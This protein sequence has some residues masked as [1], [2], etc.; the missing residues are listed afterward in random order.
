MAFVENDT[1]MQERFSL[2]LLEPGEIYFE[3]YSVYYYPPGLSEEEAIKKRQK[4]RLKICSKSIL[5]DPKDSQYPL[6]KFPFKE[7]EC[8]EEWAGSLFSKL[9]ASQRVLKLESRL[10]IEMC[11][12]NIVAPYVFRK[13]LAQH[14]FHLNYVTI[15]DC[16]PQMCQL[17]R[18]STLPLADQTAMINAIVLSRQSRVKFNTSWLED[19]YEKTVLECQADRIT[20]LVT[21][22]G[23]V[24]LTS[25]RL[26]FQAFN[27]VNPIPV[28]KIKLSDVCR[29]VKRRFLL[30]Q[31]GMEVYCR[32]GAPCS[33]LYLSLKT[34]DVRDALYTRLLAQPL[35][36]L[37]ET[38]QD[39][40]TFRWQN[41]T[42]SNLDYLLYLNSLA[43]RSFNDLTQYPVM[44]WV[45]ADYTSPDLDLLSDST[46]RDLSKPMGAL[47]PARL[48]GLKARFAEMPEPKF[49]YGSH[50]STPGYVL[51][52]LARVAPEYMLC[53]QN[54]KFDQADRMFNDISET[55]MNCL[56]GQ[57]DFKELIPEFY[58]GK[59][60]FLTNKRNINFGYRQ[61]GKPVGDVTLPA[62]AK[63]PEEFVTKLQDAL[64]SSYVSN[65]I[66][67]WI[68]LVFGYKQR[69]EE[70][71]KAD[72][73]FYYLT[74][75]GAVD[76]DSIIDLNER[77][78]LEI[79]IMEFGQ[80]P[81]QLFT[82][83]HP[84]R[85]STMP[86]PQ[87]PSFP[88]ASRGHETA[89][90]AE[91]IGEV[92]ISRDQA[93][94]PSPSGV[95]VKMLQSLEPYLRHS[96]HKEAVTDVKI[97][98]D[99]KNIY[100][101]SQDSLLKM[102]SLEDQRQLRSINLSNMALSC[103]TVM[104]DNR[105]IIVGSWDN[106]VYF[107]SVEYGRVLDS[108]IAHDDAVSSL[109][110]EN[111]ML[112]TASW[113]STVKIWQYCTPEGSRS[114]SAEY[115]MVL[116]HE[117]CVM[118]VDVRS[119]D[120]LV[121]TGTDGGMIHVWEMAT[122]SLREQYHAHDGAVNAVLFSIDGRRVFSCGRDSF[123][124]VYDME[125]S[126]EIFA[127]DV[128][129]ELRCMCLTG[130]KL[131][132]GSNEGEVIVWDMFKVALIHR[133]K[134]HTGAIT[135]LYLSESGCLVT[136]GEDKEVVLWKSSVS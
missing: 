96:L 74:Y 55:W 54:G 114:K 48:E 47:N 117:S 29:V 119:T 11:E 77:A 93:P 28:I 100:S 95:N 49:L 41:G 26:Y 46:F 8:M 105:T 33:H 6:L 1:S 20:P 107:Y 56:K 82:T 131:I 111:D 108:V 27:N 34:P 51:F 67:Q 59:G 112:I 38:G 78:S 127:K 9:D 3:D 116:D 14:L 135:C 13:E 37:D 132:G 35:V 88:D 22:P 118:C 40:M 87:G 102:Y 63:D 101:V 69:G 125:T 61:D 99:G 50:Y 21:N 64:E 91:E 109:R 7:I 84:Q 94:S 113:D 45:V 136:G 124:K 10:V 39:N 76:M 133:V 58:T 52:Y 129:Q 15:D 81:K 65:H 5:V 68:D 53:L 121:V 126:S 43:D 60:E 85:F 103:C 89:V 120:D 12:K 32:T 18:A 86:I 44:P 42:I 19:L 62:W 134:G 17:H 97:S 23:R 123:L 24:M 83:P 25:S 36:K 2:L 73:L 115:L 128:E 130:D 31:V 66:H 80:T 72:N 122:G 57:A 98:P 104:P 71:E 106:Q 70:A 4:G 110:W 90:F 79:Q 92:T 16:L 30:R 75:E